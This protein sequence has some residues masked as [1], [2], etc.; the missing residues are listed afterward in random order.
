MIDREVKNDINQKGRDGVV[1]VVMMDGWVG[2]RESGCGC[3]RKV[4][5]M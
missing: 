5:L 4:R 3:R 2:E 1:V